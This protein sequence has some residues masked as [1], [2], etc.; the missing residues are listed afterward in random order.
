MGDILEKTKIGLPRF[1]F[2]YDEG[3]FL[4]YF[5]EELG[6]NVIVS[7]ETNQEIKNLGNK[8]SNDE[9]CIS[10]KLFIGHIMYLKDKCDYL[11][12]IRFDNTGLTEQGCTNYLSL[13]DIVNNITD[14]KILNINIDHYNYKTLYKE[15]LKLFNEFKFDK[16][17]IK[18]AYLFSRIKVSKEHKNEIIKNT[19]KLYSLSKKVLIIGHPYNI[20]DDYIIKDIYKMILDSNIELIFYDKFDKD[21]IKDLSKNISKNVY[22]K[23]GK[24]A[25]GASILAKDNINGIIFISSFPCAIDSMVN[26]MIMKQTTLP[27]LNIV[28]DDLDAFSGIETRLESFIDIIEQN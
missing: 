27:Y 12:N 22:F 17:M 13:Y 24:E 21:K 15:L 26:E 19:N 16:K 11:L 20:Y 1:F 6:F 5:L 2:Y 3:R 7:P 9:M 18:N 14:L 8:Y 25:M 4:K 28:I 23:F 10:L